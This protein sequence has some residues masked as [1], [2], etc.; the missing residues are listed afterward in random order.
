MGHLP[1]LSPFSSLPFPFALKSSLSSLTFVIIFEPV[2][3][4]GLQMLTDLH[5]SN[6]GKGP[7]QG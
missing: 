1:Q 4:R 3:Q 7:D 6:V 5:L 2:T